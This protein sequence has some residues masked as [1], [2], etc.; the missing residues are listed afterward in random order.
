MKEA[1]LHSE[2]KAPV[3]S[4]YPARIFLIPALIVFFASSA[5][6]TYSAPTPARDSSVNSSGSKKKK[7][8]REE[9]KRQ[10]AIRKEMESPYKKWLDEEVPYI[11]TPEEKSSFKKLTTDEEREQFIEAFWERRNPNPGSPENEFK[12]EYYRRIA[13]ANEHYSSG[14]PGWKMDRGRIYIMYG[15]PDEIDAHP[16]GGSYVRPPCE[17]GG[18]TSTYPFED[19]TY[20]YIE[21]IGENIQL[22]FVDPSMSGEYHLTMDPGEKDALLHVP[23][24]GLTEYEMMNGGSKLDRFQNTDGTT[25]GIPMGG[26]PES[27]EEFTRLDQFAKIFRPPAVK[28][29]DLRAVV[30][31][32]ISAQLLPFNVKTDYVRITSESILT[33]ITIQIAN[34]DLEFQ[35]KDGVM[36]GVVDI[37]GQ[38]STLGGRIANSFEDS[39]VLDVPQHDF[40]SYVNRQSVYQKAV[41]LSPGRY[42]LSLVL[43]DDTSGHMGSTDLGIIVPNYSDDGLS[44]SSLILA[45][46]IQQLPTNEVGTGPFVIGSTKVRPSVTASF[47]RDQSLGMYLQVYN[48]GVDPKTHRPDADI[49][50]QILKDGKTIFTATEAAAKIQ[51]ASEQVTIRKSLPLAP[52]QPGDYTVAIKVTDNIKKKSIQPS[53]TF[54]LH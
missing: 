47:K 53:A 23:G 17:G 43:K 35:N 19:W 40:S 36:H 27:M 37:Y 12:E 4:V 8:T 51:H 33:P 10:K 25:M 52:L 21:G 1:F 24:A 11:I 26:Q 42:K 54:A 6:L 2:P 32:K 20:H 9:K 45:D 15:P 31:H 5:A 13:Y 30:T 28:F 48:L 49:Q 22:E 14:M 7:L 16:S 50:Y 34:K 38:L 41:T 3:Y 44:A 29:N 18:E 39:V 46:L